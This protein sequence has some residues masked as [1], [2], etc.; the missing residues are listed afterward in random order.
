MTARLAEL[1]AAA[2]AARYA[3]TRYEEVSTPIHWKFPD[4]T[5]VL[6]DAYMIETARLEYAAA[7]RLFYALL[8]PTLVLHLLDK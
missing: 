3:R 7:M 5:P 6:N 4:L 2:L 8:D 1:R